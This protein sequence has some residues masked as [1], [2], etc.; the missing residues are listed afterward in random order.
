MPSVAVYSALLLLGSAVFA[1][2]A[3]TGPTYVGTTGCN[4][5]RAEIAV[6]ELDRHAKA[7]DSLKPGK[8]NAAKRKVRLDPAMDYSLDRKC[9]RC[10]AT[11]Y[12]R[13][14][15]YL[16]EQ[17]T[18]DMKGVGCEMCHGPGS[19]YR[20]LHEQKRYGFSRQE[21]AAAG[22]TYAT[23]DATVCEQCHNHPHSPYNETVDA[24]YRN[25]WIRLLQDRAIY[26]VG[27]DVP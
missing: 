15:G 3:E 11:G 12:G 17:A 25:N 5:H 10:H 2:R 16:D 26:H 7:L 22:Q 9:L 24:K 27:A 18:P 21:A 19:V 1:V 14:G 6:W 13:E 23:S 4:C 20:I 8:R